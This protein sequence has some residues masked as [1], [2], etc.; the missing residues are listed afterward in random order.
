MRTAARRFQVL[1][2]EAFVDY[3][4]F[5]A[6]QP[7]K[8]GASIHGALLKGQRNFMSNPTHNPMRILF[9][10]IALFSLAIS[11]FAQGSINFQNRTAIGKGKPI[12][13][14]W[15]PPGGGDADGVPILQKNLIDSRLQSF[16]LHIVPE[17]SVFALAALG[18][19]ALFLR[20]RK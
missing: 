7:R 6:S 19:G 3:A 11:S 5:K 12:Y 18:L 16:G 14:L 17:P 2:V 8:D 10:T 15:H 9:L 13:G 20:R 4:N 1:D